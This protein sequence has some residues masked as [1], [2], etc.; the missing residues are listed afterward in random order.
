[1]QNLTAIPSCIK[2]LSLMK[3]TQSQKDLLD[4]STLGYCLTI[5]K[6]DIDHTRHNQLKILRKVNNSSKYI[7]TVL[8]LF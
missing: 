5:S 2:K 1:M 4:L 7:F 6:K 3:N 8:I